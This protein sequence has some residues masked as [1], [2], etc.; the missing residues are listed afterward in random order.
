MTT[1][2]ISEIKVGNRI[3]KDMG[4]LKTLANSIADIGLLHPIVITPDKRLIAG[5]R[6]LA[7]FKHLG[8]TE[9]PATVVTLDKIVRGEYAENGHRKDFVPSEIDAI[10]RLVEPLEKAAAKERM[11]EGA[12]VGKVST[13]SGKTRDKVGALA[14][15]SG[16]TVEKITA[17]VEAAEQDPERF[18]PLVADMDRTGRVNGVYRRLQI[19]K[20][21]DAIKREPPPLPSQ[22]PYRVLVADPPW[23][24]EKRDNDP[25]RR[26]MLPYPTMALADICALDV[27]GL[28]HDDA[29]LWLWTT[30]HHMA[31]ALEVMTAW[32]FEQKTILTWAKDRMGMGDWLRGQSEHC[33]VG[34]KGKP[35]VTLTNQTTLLQAPVRGHS[36]KPDEFYALVEGLCP[37]PRYAELFQRTAREGWD[38]HG[39]EVH[40]GYSAAMGLVGRCL[41]KP[42]F[43]VSRGSN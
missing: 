23:R 30:N 33:I 39:D 21:S 10:R 12:R 28:A 13:P 6:R 5:E 43:E 24:Y 14:G 35:T 25:S 17:I 19:A 15:I 29:I 40:A 27:G 37:A 16:R 41:N 32:G 7:A 9:I 4:D 31:E 38:G 11:S 1:I 22:G 3:R 36:Q 42:G 18:E 34:T 2:L 26:G 20:R 8:R